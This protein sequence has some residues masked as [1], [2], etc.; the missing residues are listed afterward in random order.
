MAVPLCNGLARRHAAV[1]D[2]RFAAF[3]IGP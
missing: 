2:P 1:R 3:A